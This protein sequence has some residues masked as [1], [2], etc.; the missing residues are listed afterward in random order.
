MSE[1]G[2]YDYEPVPGLPEVPPAGETVMWQGAP[3]WRVL[4]RRVF[5]VRKVAAYFLVLMAWRQF[6]IYSQGE[7]LQA[8]LSSGVALTVAAALALGLLSLLAVLT[9]RTTLYTVTS[10]RVVLRV[11]I[12]LPMTINIPFSKIAAAAVRQDKDGSGNVAMQMT[13]GEHMSYVVLW[14]HVR[15]FSG[16]GVQ[17]AFRGLA[18]VQPVADVFA[19]AIKA[20]H[21]HVEP[22]QSQPTDERDDL[23]LAAAGR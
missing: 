19:K 2:E 6:S 14:P 16:A 15:A 4:A 13:K 10:E 17:P 11:G 18:D 7:G 1:L 5:H 23:R 9:A 8:P 3:D 21:R 22:A 12:A 20:R